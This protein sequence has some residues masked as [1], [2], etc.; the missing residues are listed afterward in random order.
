[1]R[2][3]EHRHALSTFSTMMGALEG[4]DD[5]TFSR[6]V[7]NLRSVSIESRAGHGSDG[8]EQ[9]SALPSV[10]EDALPSARPTEVHEPVDAGLQGAGRSTRDTTVRRAGE[11]PQCS[12]SS[13]DAWPTSTDFTQWRRSWMLQNRSCPHLHHSNRSIAG[14]S[15]PLERSTSDPGPAGMDFK[16]CKEF[17]RQVSILKDSPDSRGRLKARGGARLS[18]SFSSDFVTR[19]FPA[20][21]ERDIRRHEGTRRVST[22]IAADTVA[23]SNQRWEDWGHVHNAGSEARLERSR[24]SEP[25]SIIKN[26]GQ[27]GPRDCKTPSCVSFPA[28]TRPL[29]GWWGW[30]L[31]HAVRF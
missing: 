6:Y 10:G 28:V 15:G 4:F 7:E 27:K 26:G 11:A 16:R 21:C 12:P 14:E 20:P 22:E 8:R 19:E 3:S 13:S 9:D 24:S 30:G 29:L 2:S 1:M 31:T 18:V 25:R 5:E 23:A 17:Y